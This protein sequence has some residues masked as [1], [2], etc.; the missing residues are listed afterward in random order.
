[1]NWQMGPFAAFDVE[2]TGVDPESDRI[3]TAAVSLVGAGIAGCHES[4]LIDPGVEIPPQATAVHGIDTAKARAEGAASREA[5]E[6]IT[7]AL[8]RHLRSGA[9]I[10]AFNARFDLTMLDREAR[11]HRLMPLAERVGGVE[12]MLVIDPFVLDKQV[13]R[14]RKGKRT[15]EAVC[16]HYRVQL[17]QAHAAN[18][19]AVAAARVAYRIG[20]SFPEVGELELRRLHVCQVQWAREQATSLQEYFFSIGRAEQVQA[21]WP[22]V[23][24]GRAGEEIALA[25]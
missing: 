25:A 21:A 16:L 5:V 3:V 15:L 1:M 7:S 23:P 10:V 24:I 22:V 9:P 11:R 19:D 13:D 12:A 6:E 20:R 4:W 14:F 18:A 2:T 17:E 8:A